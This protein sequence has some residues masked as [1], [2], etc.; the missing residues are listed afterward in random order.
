MNMNMV[1]LLKDV[2][3][4][5][6]DLNKFNRNFNKIKLRGYDRL[7]ANRK[8]CTFKLSTVLAIIDNFG[9]ALKDYLFCIESKQQ[10]ILIFNKKRTFIITPDSIQFVTGNSN[11]KPTL[12]NIQDMFFED[13]KHDYKKRHDI[14]HQTSPTASFNHILDTMETEGTLAQLRVG[15]KYKKAS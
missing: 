3:E 9:I 4:S 5:Q 14:Y 12:A 6:K 8:M 11:V 2:T 1:R 7:Q 15:R 10:V 13:V